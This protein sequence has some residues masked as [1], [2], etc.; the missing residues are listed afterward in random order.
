MRQ[1]AMMEVERENM[2]MIILFF[3]L[4]NKT[5]ANHVGNPDYKFNPA[6]IMMD[7]AG[8]NLQGIKDAMGSEYPGKIVTCQ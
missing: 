1:L 6:L 2:E 3:N 4:L 5:L 8:A 7:E